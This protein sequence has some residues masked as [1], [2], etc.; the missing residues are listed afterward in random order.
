MR[1]YLVRSYHVLFSLVLLC[2]GL[3]NC[4]SLEPTITVGFIGTTF[5][6]NTDNEIVS[7]TSGAQHLAAFMMAVDEIN[8]S[9]IYDVLL[10]PEVSLGMTDYF[11]AIQDETYN[12]CSAARDLFLSKNLPQAVIIADKGPKAMSAG[13]TLQSLNIASLYSS[14]RSSALS[15]SDVYSGTFRMTA[16]EAQD[17]A[18]LRRV[19]RHF[20]W[21]RVAVVYSEDNFG[22]DAYFYF[23]TQKLDGDTGDEIVELAVESFPTHQKSFSQELAALDD[24]GAT[25]FVVFLSK[26]R[27]MALFLVQGYRAGIFP[28][29][30]QVLMVCHE[31]N[32]QVLA[33]VGK[34]LSPTEN[35]DNVL[36]GL[37]SVAYYP[38]H[39]LSTSRGQQFITNYKKLF[40][41]RQVDQAGNS[42]CS[43]S[44]N[45][46]RTAENGFPLYKVKARPW[47]CTGLSDFSKLDQSG[48]DIDPEILY[49][50]DATI[51]IA[52]AL[53]YLIKSKGVTNSSS[54]LSGMLYDLLVANGSSIEIKGASGMLHW[55]SGD[56]HA[57][58]FGQGDRVSG[59]SFKLLGYFPQKLLASTGVSV[60]DGL[61]LVGYFNGTKNAGVT[62]VVL[63]VSSIRGALDAGMTEDNLDR[64]T[65]C[66][67]ADGTGG[68]LAEV[69]T[70]DGMSCQWARYRTINMKTP[71][72]DM[73][74]DL[75]IYT[76]PNVYLIVVAV[77]GSICL[78]VAI[79]CITTLYIFR[80][81]HNVKYTQPTVLAVMFLGY[82]ILGIKVL[83]SQSTISRGFCVGDK[84]L[85]HIG[86]SCSFVPLIVKLWRLDKIVNSKT[87]K[88]VKITD[89][90]ALS[91]CLRIILILIMLLGIDSA[92]AN[93]GENN[94]SGFMKATTTVERNQQIF[95]YYCGVSPSAGS[96]ATTSFVYTFQSVL[97]LAAIIYLYKTRRLPSNVNECGTIA[98]MLLAVTVLVVVTSVVVGIAN[99]DPHLNFLVIDLSFSL[100]VLL[101]VSYYWTPKL[102][103]IAIEYFKAKHATGAAAADNVHTSQRWNAIKQNVKLLA[104]GAPG[105]EKSDDR[106]KQKV[107]L[108]KLKQHDLPSPSNTIQE[109]M[110]SELVNIKGTDRKAK[111]CQDQISYFQSVLMAL[112]EIS[113][114]SSNSSSK[115]SNASMMMPRRDK[116]ASSAASSIDD[117]QHPEGR[118]RES[119]SVLPINL[120]SDAHTVTVT[121]SE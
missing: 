81:H 24:S 20:G 56:P 96:L 71:A 8:D 101:S 119:S 53:H 44:K 103:H 10:R 18:V 23:K 73:Q 29:G 105:E 112:S 104:T 30:T 41:T 21:R 66:G 17:G 83:S 80:D 70:I 68:S 108:G 99:F 45:S 35:I 106:F 67:M 107:L 37:M 64:V 19:C 47:I 65:L 32:V 75:H 59:H 114:S 74:P 91:I 117:H 52:K 84:W 85:S 63:K 55:Y 109:S 92:V 46:N 76:L 72:I 7:S 31:P 48:S 113:E 42:I 36:L 90:D 121:T 89:K 111:F 2:F 118:Y 120:S 34:L 58:L 11:E 22:V 98:P 26:A 93:L 6:T 57:N 95:T 50:Y 97:M 9:H 87:L 40:P 102:T 61:A 82:A 100:G 33:E 3:G 38:R 51:A 28:Q 79:F 69:T 86:F 110:I 94:V 78:A 60:E 77:L 39:H 62:D 1:S 5:E 15:H 115:D 16:S 4:A 88:R 54:A 25:V 49:T 43:F 12:G 14:E 116:P 27:S 13:K